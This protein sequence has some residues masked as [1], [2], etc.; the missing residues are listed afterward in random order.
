MKTQCSLPSE[1]S[2]ILILYGL[3][4]SG[5]IRFRKIDG[6]QT[7]VQVV[8]DSKEELKKRAS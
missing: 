4:L 3:L 1:K 6:W 2:A 7:L 5:Q 8:A